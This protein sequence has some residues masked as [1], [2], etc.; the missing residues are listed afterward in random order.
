MAITN[1]LTWSWERVKLSA[2]SLGDPGLDDIKPPIPQ[3]RDLAVAQI[4]ISDLREA[5]ARGMQDFAATRTDVLTLCLLYPLL[6]LVFASLASGSGMMPL[7]FPLASGFAL[8]APVAAI[9]LYE[10]S[11]RREMGLQA[12]W[13]DMF[14]VL[15]SPALG[16]IVLLGLLLAG[17]YGIWLVVASLIYDLTLGPQP[18]VSWGR[19]AQ[20]LFTTPQGWT[21]IV[22]GMFVG[23]LFAVLVLMISLVSFPLMLD[24]H[25]G[26]STAMAVSVRAVMANKA[27]IAAWGLILAAGLLAGSI[28]LLLGLAVVLPVLGHASWHLYRRMIH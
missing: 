12:R 17:I 28:P 13:T 4:Q 7:V 20:D 23:F 6:G 18:P 15:R 11:R 25:V 27:A 24:R 5:L 2:A 10:L 9:G 8:M 22:V 26:V 19:F 16:Q 21:M 1:P 14:A 3:S